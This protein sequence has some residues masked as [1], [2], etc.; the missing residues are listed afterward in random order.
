MKDKKRLPQMIIL[1]VV[2]AACAGLVVAKMTGKPR[3]AQSSPAAQAGQASAPQ[4]VGPQV[5]APAAITPEAAAVVAMETDSKTASRRDPFAPAMIASTTTAAA[6]RAPSYANARVSVRDTLPPLVP[7]LRFG[8]GAARDETLAQDDQGF[9]RP[10]AD[11]FPRFVLT[12]VVTGQTNV[13][14]IRDG[15]GRYVVKEG[16]LIEGQYRVVTVSQEGVLLSG[17]DRSV[18]LKLGGEANAS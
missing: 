17:D 11:S 8:A 12:G 9:P 7:S 10:A 5:K 4:P 6:P 18:F 13:A 2:V 16:E 14:I 15:E 1:G 3:S